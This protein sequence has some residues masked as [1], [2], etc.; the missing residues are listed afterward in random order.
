VHVWLWVRR[1]HSWRAHEARRDSRAVHRVGDPACRGHRSGT[2]T[3][4]PERR[5]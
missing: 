5:V 1:L 3:L 4:G 2:A